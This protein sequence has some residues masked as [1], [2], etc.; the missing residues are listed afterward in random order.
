MGVGCGND[1]YWRVYN[2]VHYDVDVRREMTQ[3][4]MKKWMTMYCERRAR[5]TR[6]SR[7]NDVVG[8]VMVLGQGEN[9]GRGVKK[10][11]R[12]RSAH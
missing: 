3:M 10:K 6:K 1:G 5:K 9:C 8:S 2:L 11:G 12:K 4:G 7:E